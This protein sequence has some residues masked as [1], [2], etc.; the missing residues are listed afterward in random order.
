MSK[1]MNALWG[2]IKMAR[3]HRAMLK[4]TQITLDKA[5]DTMCPNLHLELSHG[6]FRH[7]CVLGYRKLLND[8][9]IICYSIDSLNLMTVKLSESTFSAQTLEQWN[10]AIGEWLQNGDAVKNADTMRE[11]L[12]AYYRYRADVVCITVDNR[13]L[14]KEHKVEPFVHDAFSF[15]KNVLKPES[16]HMWFMDTVSTA[17]TRQVY[18]PQSII[19]IASQRL[20]GIGSMQA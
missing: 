3:S 2:I 16:K 10:A 13:G 5:I 7:L 6:S 4:A 20:N 9:E 11:I 14:A 19:K 18:L 1:T 8:L 17:C 12:S 15:Q